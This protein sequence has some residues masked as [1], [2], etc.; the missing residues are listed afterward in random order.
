MPLSRARRTTAR[1]AAFIPGESPPLVITARVLIIASLLFVR[2]SSAHP[3]CCPATSLP[4]RTYTSIIPKRK[5]FYSLAMIA[6]PHSCFLFWFSFTNHVPRFETCFKLDVDEAG[7][8]SVITPKIRGETTPL[9]RDE[10]TRIMVVE[11]F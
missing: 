8:S 11:K 6:R 3:P 10:T 1:T 7:G 2:K 5:I 9:Y 4:K